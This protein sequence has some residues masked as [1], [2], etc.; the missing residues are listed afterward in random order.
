MP[1]SIA[2]PLS[3]RGIFV[4]CT[5]YRAT[6]AKRHE[7]IVLIL[8]SLAKWWYEKGLCLTNPG[9]MPLY[10]L[11]HDNKDGAG[12]GVEKV[13]GQ[14]AMEDLGTQK[15][16]VP[17]VGADTHPVIADIFKRKHDDPIQNK[18]RKKF[19]AHRQQQVNLARKEESSDPHHEWKDVHMTQVDVRRVVH[20]V[21]RSSDE[22]GE[23]QSNKCWY[24]K[25]F[26]VAIEIDGN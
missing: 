20:I 5:V 11:R 16:G 14:V 21:V 9:R 4:L 10:E 17:G 3:Y 24:R 8:D 1:Q 2:L 26:E 15:S 7:R 12:G 23:A 19:V 13:H 6:C 25:V 22:H 18:R